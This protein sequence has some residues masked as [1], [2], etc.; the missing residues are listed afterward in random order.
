MSPS[1]GGRAFCGHC[2]EQVAGGD[3]AGCEARL[4]LEPPRFCRSCGR[5]MKVQVTP[6]SWTA[7]CVEHGDLRG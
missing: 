4:A 2:G 5:R 1:D 7:S 3:H 6:T